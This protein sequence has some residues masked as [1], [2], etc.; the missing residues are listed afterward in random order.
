VL[1]DR[2]DQ[3]APCTVVDLDETDERVLN[4][5]LNRIHGEWDAEKLGQVL[6]ELAEDEEACA[7]MD[8][9]IIDNNELMR[10]V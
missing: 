6:T 10:W 3:R 5:A 8:Q 9:L 2:G 7:L 1:R 4:L